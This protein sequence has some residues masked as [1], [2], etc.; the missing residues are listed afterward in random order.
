MATTKPRQ[1]ND[2]TEAVSSSRPPP[3]AHQRAALPL[4]P[5][6]AIA[7]ACQ[8]GCN[9]GGVSSPLLATGQ[10][11]SR[12][13]DK[14]GTYRY[15]CALHPEMTGIVVVTDAPAGTASG[16]TTATARVTTASTLHAADGG[17]QIGWQ[18]GMLMGIALALIGSLGIGLPLVLGLRR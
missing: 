14:P 6:W 7:T 16:P 9:D 18:I 8:F 4:R 17:G 12:T 10:A 3:S 15:I 1:R 5:F 2:F 13:F 11:W